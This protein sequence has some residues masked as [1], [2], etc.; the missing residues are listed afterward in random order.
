MGDPTYVLLR[1]G[2]KEAQCGSLRWAK[3]ASFLHARSPK[4]V[5]LPG[6]IVAV[7]TDA[8]SFVQRL[9]ELEDEGRFDS[10][11]QSNGCA[12]SGAI[13]GAIHQTR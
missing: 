8:A 3:S 4:R 7:G 12:V 9:S 5:F 1:A 13:N 6:L 2:R 10:G 11:Q